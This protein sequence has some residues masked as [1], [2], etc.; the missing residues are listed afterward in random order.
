MVKAG[1][2]LH[3]TRAASP[4]FVRPIF[5]R[6]IREL[7]WTTY[8]GWVWLDGYQVDERGDATARRSIFVR[9]AALCPAP[10]RSLQILVPIRHRSV[11]VPGS[12]SSA[13]SVDGAAGGVDA[14]DRTDAA[15]QPLQQ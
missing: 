9:R 8:D 12:S 6:L 13:R 4:Q 2:L 11:R 1:D 3:V 14:V 10:G 15:A 7:D 5:F